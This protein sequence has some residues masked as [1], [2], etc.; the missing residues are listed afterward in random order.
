VLPEEAGEQPRPQPDRV[1]IPR[2]DLH[3]LLISGMHLMHGFTLQR[4]IIE[5]FQ[6]IIRRK[7]MIEA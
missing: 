4:T 1:D 5:Q 3:F 6:L 7:R 2:G